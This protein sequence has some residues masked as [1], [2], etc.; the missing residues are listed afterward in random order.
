M[1]IV[2]FARGHEMSEISQETNDEF[3]KNKGKS[4]AIDLGTVTIH[5]QQEKEI[6]V[7]YLEELSAGNNLYKPT[8]LKFE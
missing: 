3:F 4:S 7:K 5:N 1:Y 6:L 2:I 8:E